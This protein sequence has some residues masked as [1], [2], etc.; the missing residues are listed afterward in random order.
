[1]DRF[2]SADTTDILEVQ[3]DL[4]DKNLYAYCDN[5]PV[6]RLDVNG[7]IWITV[8]I[9]AA[10]GAVGGIIG[11]ASSAYT[12]S[13]ITG[14]INWKS[15]AVAGGAGF[16]SGLIAASPLSIGGQVGFGALIGAAS[17]VA[18]AKV[19]SEVIAVDK[20]I[21]AAGTGAFSGRIGGA[22]AN[23]NMALTNTI[24]TSMK[25]TVKMKS[26][27]NT[28]YAAKQVA[29]TKAWRNNRLSA[30]AVEGSARFSAG[31]GISN[32]ITGTWTK[33]KNWVSSWF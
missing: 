7:E 29:S 5:N 22:G 2:I 10:G 21:V 25:T 4:Y 26:R 9:M 14:S 27:N 24:Q 23:Q 1:M 12:Q 6:L 11:A 18:D 28:S 32:A 30:S 19:N 15:V 3:G 33:I 13:L 31:I 17:Y 8:G 16:V 20:L